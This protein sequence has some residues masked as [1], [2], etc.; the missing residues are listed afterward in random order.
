MPDDRFI[1]PRAGRSHKITML[2]DLEYRVWTQY[3]L[4]AD[5]FGVMHCTAVAIQNANLH[6]ARRPAKM[7][8]RCLEA[9]VS[10]GLVRRFEHQGQPY[11]FQPDWQ[12]WQKVE[13]PRSTVNPAPM[14]ADLEACDQGTRLLF[15]QHPGG[16][17]KGRRATDSPNESAAI[18]IVVGAHSE[19][20]CRIDSQDVPTTRA[21]ARETA[22]ANGYR[23]PAQAE[24]VQGEFPGDRWFVELKAAYPPSAVSDGHLTQTAFIDAVLSNG[25]P[26]STFTVMMAN[27]DIQKRGHQWRVKNMI[28]RLDRWLREGLW[29][30]QHE[31]APPSVLLTDKTAKTLEAAAA[32]KRLGR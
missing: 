2:T 18:P 28:P 14:G 7:I 3:L 26:Q 25:T 10:G 22:K 8:K 6:L 31:E 11:I 16:K 1:H 30:Q 27:L 21:G 32:V 9:L 12:R 17:R 29:Q 5:D 20:A 15:V 4:C 19:R 23:L 24:G 13:Y